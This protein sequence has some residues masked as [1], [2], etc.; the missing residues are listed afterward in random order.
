MP[1]MNE[2]TRICPS[3]GVEYL[4]TAS[5]CSDCHV[6]LRYPEE[7]AAAVSEEGADELTGELVLLRA[8]GAAWIEELAGS[9]DDAGIP[10]R[11]GPV[12]GA[13]SR[14]RTGAIGLYVRPEDV[15][16]ARAIDAEHLR[17]QIPDMPDEVA[18][19][20]GED[21]CPAC[22]APCPAEASECPDCGLVFAPEPDVG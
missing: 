13:G 14:A 9:L 20:G 1:P 2:P 10:F 19:P 7:I 16:R 3:C 11:T 8:E 17:E 15:E 5:E 21:E 12:G 22:G 6:A 4:H 18:A